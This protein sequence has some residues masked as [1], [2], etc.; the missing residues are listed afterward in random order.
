MVALVVVWAFSYSI[1]IRTLRPVAPAARVCGGA[2]T[3]FSFALLRN[4]DHTPARHVPNR[5]VLF[6]RIFL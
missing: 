1:E 6:T 2:D 4:E 5:A 3:V